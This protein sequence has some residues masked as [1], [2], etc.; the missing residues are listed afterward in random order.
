MFE[1]EKEYAYVNCGHMC[2]CK[3]CQQGKWLHKCLY[4]KLSHR[5]K[6]NNK[7]FYYYY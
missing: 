3:Q 7:K 6:I 4:V 2:L 1:N 5:I